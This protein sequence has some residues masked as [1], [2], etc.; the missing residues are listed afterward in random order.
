MKITFPIVKTEYKE[1]CPNC[2][3]E[4]PFEAAAG[5]GFTCQACGTH[6]ERLIIIDPKLRWWLDEEQTYYH[7]SVGILIVRPDGK[8]LFYELTK[9]PYGLT[10]PAGHVDVEETP[11]A[12]AVR[13]SQEEV[14][15]AI[16]DP[17]LIAQDVIYGDKCRRGSDDHKWSLFMARI[18]NEDA[19]RIQLDAHEGE[20]AKWLHPEAV[21]TSSLP[22]AV[23][24]IFDT[25]GKEIE[26]AIKQP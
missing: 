8:I 20:D 19:Q 5:G 13:E 22:F 7:E 18:S 23:R 4:G 24:F 11:E 10:I 26:Q 17:A 25:Y 3:S 16:N 15:I 12:A 21:T 1:Y 9:Y 14:G 6:N 2:H